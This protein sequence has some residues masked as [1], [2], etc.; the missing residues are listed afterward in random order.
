VDPEVFGFSCTCQPSC[1]ALPDIANVTFCKVQNVT[2]QV[3]VCDILK[4][5]NVTFCGAD[6]TSE[7]YKCHFSNNK[8]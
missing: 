8:M 6:V 3:D 2:F 4:A 1:P 7:K 5:G